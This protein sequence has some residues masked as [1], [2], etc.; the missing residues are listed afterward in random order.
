M[1]M[2][3]QIT[4][5]VGKKFLCWVHKVYLPRTGRKIRNMETRRE[6]DDIRFIRCGFGKYEFCNIYCS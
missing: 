3:I 1:Q 2:I 6:K 4:S 5:A